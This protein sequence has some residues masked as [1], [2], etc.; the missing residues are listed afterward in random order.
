MGEFELI[1]QLTQGLQGGTGVEV[2]VGDDCALLNSTTRELL[3]ATCD[4][5]VEEVHFS[6]RFSSPQQIGRKALAVNL[7]DIAAMGGIPR[8]ALIS[9]ILPP[10]HPYLTEVYM[11]LREEAQRYETAIV[12]GNIASGKQFILDITLLGAVERDHVLLRSNARPG[13]ILCVTGFPGEAAAGLHTLFHPD[14][15]YDLTAQER[16][17]TKYRTPTPRLQEGR[18]LSHFGPQIITALLDVSDGVSGDLRHICEKSGVGAWIEAAQLPISTALQAVAGT[19]VH[20]PRDWFL[21][22]GEDYELL[23][24]VTPSHVEAVIATIQQE[25]GTIV[26]PIGIIHAANQGLKL[27]LPDGSLTPLPN[28]SWDHLRPRDKTEGVANTPTYHDP[29]T[30]L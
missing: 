24:T 22:G 21:H 1:A 27:H 16:T 20:D 18:I 2:G 26:T 9:L 13:D 23:F 14:A 4:S 10:E 6:F 28:A 19:A 29:T 30:I 3:L 8:H 12:G 5:Q 17:R 11:G 25:T 7:S 15:D